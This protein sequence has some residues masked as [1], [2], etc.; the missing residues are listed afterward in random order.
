TPPAAHRS[1]TEGAAAFREALAAAVAGRLDHAD[2]PVSVQL[3]GGLDSTT[4][5][6]LA[7][8][9]RPLLLTTAGR[10]PIDDDLR[11]ARRVAEHFP[12]AAHRVVS[13]EEAPEFF[14]EPDAPLSGMDEPAPFAAGAAR[15]HYAARLLA[16]H[17]TRLHLNGQ[18][19]DEVLLAPL[20]YLGTAVRAVPRLG[21]RHVR[22]HAALKH[23]PVWRMAWA[24]WRR[25]PYGTWLRWAAEHLHTEPPVADAVTGWEAPPLLPPWA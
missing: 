21:W 24:A 10:S 1:V 19:G 22:G 13:A 23:S 4:L 2:G 6:C 16:E 18:G 12:G 3:S 5:A 17:G 7:A 25:Q 8:P 14:A 20:A 15:T 11:W 9:A